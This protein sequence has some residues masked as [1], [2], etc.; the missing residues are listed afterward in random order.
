MAAQWQRILLYSSAFVVLFIVSHIF[1]VSALELAL[2]LMLVIPEIALTIIMSLVKL[3]V[4]HPTFIMMHHDTF[5]IIHAYADT[6]AAETETQTQRL[7]LGCEHHDTT[8]PKHHHHLY[9]FLVHRFYHRASCPV[10]LYRRI[11]NKILFIF[12]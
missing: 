2:I 3:P 7:R 5:I 8:E 6:M 4:K 1:I 10:H 12:L 9:H 11:K